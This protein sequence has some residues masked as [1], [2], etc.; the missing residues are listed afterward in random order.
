MEVYNTVVCGGTFDHFHAGHRAFLQ[1]AL[2]LG[3]KVIIGITVDGF[4]KKEYAESSEPFVKRKQQVL[5]F[6]STRHTKTEIIPIHDMYGST[7]SPKEQ[8]DA[9]IVTRT[10]ESG[11]ELINKE[12]AKRNLPLLSVQI[13][14]FVLA[15]DEKPITATRIRSGEINRNGRLYIPAHWKEKDHLLSQPVRKRLQ[16]PFGTLL[17]KIPH[18]KNGKH[19]ITVGDVVT[20][21]FNTSGIK[22]KVAIIDFVVE[23]KKQHASIYEHGFLGEELLLTTINP[24][25]KVTA[26]LLRTIV[27]AKAALTNNQRIIIKVDGEEDLAVLAVILG[28]PL[29]YVIYYGQPGVGIVEVVITEENKDKAYSYL[30]RPSSY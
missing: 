5:Q 1:A 29:G 13:I 21:T 14:P 23:R 12:R 10:T 8:L 4:G 20:K 26:S 27:V 28:F 17:T 6:L 11:A 16:K 19:I 7:L 18:V 22:A 24:A 2:G 15:E 3:R 30:S 25:G 9:I